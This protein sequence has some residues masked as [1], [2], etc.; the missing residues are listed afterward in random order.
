MLGRGKERERERDRLLTSA[1]E[2]EA[3]V[4]ALRWL[5]WNAVTNGA[6]FILPNASSLWLE[7]PW[8]W[9]VMMV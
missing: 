6:N 5:D 9:V 2:T 1:Y 7:R 3:R 4:R 8:M